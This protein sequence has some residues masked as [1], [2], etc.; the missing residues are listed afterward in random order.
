V[1]FTDA[2]SLGFRPS[3]FDIAISGFMGWYDCFDFTQGIF[4]QSDTKVNEIWRVLR[5]G[6]RFICCSWEEQ[7]DVSWMEEAIIRHYPAIL[8]DPEYLENR[9][10]GMAYEKASGYEI[11]FQSAGFKDIEIVREKMVFIS[12]DE[13]EW[14]QQ[15]QHLGWDSLLEKI[16]IKAI[17]QLGEVK[18]AVFKDLQRYKHADGIRFSKAVFF[19]CG[20]K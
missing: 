18:E 8:D 7:D 3:S 13:E 14:W 20:V 4:T 17:N 6:G 9:P 2:K 15:M 12:T 11:I 1:L 5:D 10:I 19:V 16:E